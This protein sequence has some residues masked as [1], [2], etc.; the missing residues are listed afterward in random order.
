MVPL[1]K[2]RGTNMSQFINNAIN[3]AVPSRKNLID[4]IIDV[5]AFPFAVIPFLIIF[6][7]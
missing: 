1:A 4:N 7:S 2:T 3:D 6:V 5:T